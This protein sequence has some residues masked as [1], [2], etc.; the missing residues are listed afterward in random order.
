MSQVQSGKS[1]EYAIAYQLQKIT[2]AT[3]VENKHLVTARKYY[4][5]YDSVE[6][7]KAMNAA[8][9]I[10]GFLT[11]V[12]KRLK[13]KPCVLRL[14]SDQAGKLGDVRDIVIETPM[15]EI[16]ISAKNRHFGVKNPRLSKNIDFGRKWIGHPVSQTYWDTVMPIFSKMQNRRENG[17]LWRN[18]HDKEDKFY[19]PLLH[20]FNIELQ[21]IYD[22]DKDNTP[23]NLLHYLLGQHDF[24]KTA[25]DNGTAIVQS[26][27][28]NGSLLWGKKLPL[29]TIIENRRNTT[30]TTTL[31][32]FDKGWQISFRIH[33]AE[34]KVT[35]SLKF[36]IQLTG[37]PHRL[38]RHEINYLF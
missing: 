13:Q 30:K 21:R 32:S 15:G 33:N 1:F 27:N 17:Q 24:Y 38:S 29:P 4:V 14:Q 8:Q 10:V 3:L 12:D 22:N 18:I 35:P 36:D 16:G 37:L 19:V 5:T 34:S 31:Y 26:F 20:A 2:Q 11:R 9:K 25:K 28:I 6:Q 23:K 7:N